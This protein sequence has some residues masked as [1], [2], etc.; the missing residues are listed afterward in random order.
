MEG[1]FAKGGERMGKMIMWHCIIRVQIFVIALILLFA[2]AGGRAYAAEQEFPCAEDIA[3]YCKEVK[4]GGGRI[5]KCL[6]EHK[7]ELSVSCKAK[8]EESK[9]RLAEVRQACRGDTQ[10][11][12]K[13]VLPGEGRILKCLREHM[14]ELSN[15]CRKILETPEEK[16]KEKKESRQ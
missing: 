2:S 13:D 16:A 15:A 6:N 4:A 3:K 1:H 9:K 14:Q 11:F 12:C 7:N 10:K 5:L 8:L